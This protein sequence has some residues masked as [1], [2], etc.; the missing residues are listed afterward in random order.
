MQTNH[1]IGVIK[2]WSEMRDY[3]FGKN[4]P[5]KLKHAVKTLKQTIK[6]GY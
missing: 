4:G 2:W 6:T 5:L 3:G 1:P